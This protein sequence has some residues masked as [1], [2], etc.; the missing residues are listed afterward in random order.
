[1]DSLLDYSLPERMLVASRALWFYASKLAWPTDLA[2][3]YPRWDISLGDA[4]AWLYLA[5]A[6][7]LA[8][9]LWFMRRRVGRGPLAGALFF[10]VTLSP[11]LGFVNHGYM[12]YSFVADR[13]QYLAGI[14]VIAVLIGAAVHGASRLSG[15]LKL[16]AA[17]L[18][19]VVLALL[20]TATWRQAG[21]YR[22]TVT[23]FS[24]IVSLNPE[25]RNA[26]IYL[27]S[28]L[29]RAGRPEEALAAARI[30]V[31]NRPDHADA[32]ATLGG[33]LVDT[34][35]FIEAEEVLDLGRH[36]EL[37][38]FTRGYQPDRASSGVVEN[39]S[40]TMY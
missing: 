26:H 40:Q 28:A 17:G 2:V 9:T 36:V 31:E 27:S 13:F 5:G 11:V 6:T 25:A 14:G 18:L 23:L 8:A 21:I 7:A 20:G 37:I 1:M 33:L 16:G 22:D 34:E 29:T 39:L 38:V 15:G 35:R 10:A 3:I 19:V 30:A 32:Y 24:H 12:K 4:W